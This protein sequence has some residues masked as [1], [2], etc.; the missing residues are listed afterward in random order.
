MARRL[1]GIWILNEQAKLASL[2]P[3]AKGV[4]RVEIG[5]RYKAS[6]FWVGFKKLKA[7]EFEANM[8]AAHLDK[9]KSFVATASGNL[10]ATAQ[11]QL[12]GAAAKFEAAA[13][14]ARIRSIGVLRQCR[15]SPRFGKLRPVLVSSSPRS[16]R[17][18]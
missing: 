1:F 5:R 17:E 16:R 11:S 14:L 12:K 18:Y 15:Q 2:F 3:R 10:E 8:I 7:V 13:S 9:V 6:P 4:S